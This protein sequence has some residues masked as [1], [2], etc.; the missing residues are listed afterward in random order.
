[1][2]NFLIALLLVVYTFSIGIKAQDK[3]F[4]ED[5]Y[6]Y[7]ENTEVYEVGQEDGRAFHIPE[8]AIS[9]NG[10]WKF[11]YADNPSLIPANFFEA[12][13]NTKS[14]RE[15]E[16]PSNWEMQGFGQPLFR[17]TP[18]PFKAN[19]PFIPHD[20][21]PTGAYKREFTIPSSW[22][23][24]QIFLRFE[25]VA[26]A[27]FVWI[28][29]Q[30]VGYNEGAQEPSEY[31]VT[32]Y[33]KPGKNSLAV[34]VTKYS[35]G[36]YLEGQD[37]WRLAGIFDDVWIYATKQARIFDWYVVTDFDD[38]YTD[39]N[40]SI[41]VDVRTYDAGL[42]GF[43][44]S[45]EVSRGGVAVAKMTERSGIMEPKA[46]RNI[47]LKALVKSPLKWTAET[48]ELYDMT[49]TLTDGSDKLI[50]R[51][52]KKIGFKKT[53]IV[54]GVFL[55]NGKKIKVNAI[56]SHMQH[57]DLGHTM[58]E[59]TI[60]KDMELLKKFNFNG[61]R[62]SHY[63]PVNRYLELADEYGLYIIDEC[64]DEAHAT[65]YLSSKPEWEAMYRERSRK[66]VLRDRNYPSILFWSAGNE[67][68]EGPNIAAV[69]DEGRKYDPTRFWM[70]GGNDEKNPAEDIIGP[71]YPLPLE[72][73]VLYGLDKEDMRPSFMDE[74]LSIAGNGG[75][76]MT[77]YWSVIY[78]HDKIL[79][80]AIWDFVSPG[81]TEYERVIK[82]ESPYNTQVSIMGRAKRNKG[83]WGYCLD[84]HTTDQW[85]EVYRADNVEVD[86]N[87]ITLSM[88]VFP[89]ERNS[90][91]GYFLTKG[92]NQ[93]G[94]RQIGEE[95]LLFYIDTGKRIEIFAELPDDWKNNWHN[96][97]AVYDGSKMKLFIDGSLVAEGNA[98]GNIRNLPWPICIGR[99][100]ESC[101]QETRVYFCDAIVDNVRIFTEAY[102]PN[103]EL[104][105]D[106]SVLW[107]DFESETQGEKYFS[108]GIGA[109]TY[110]AIWPDRV[111]QPEMWEFKKSTQ[112]LE[113]DLLN[114]EEGLVEF[115][116]RNSFTDAS[117]Y[118]TTWT[119]TEDE[120][121]LQSG[122][123]DLSG[124]APWSRTVI[125]VPFKKPASLV[126]GKEY[127][128]NF[129]TVLKEDKLWAQKGHEVSWGQFELK[130][131]NIPAPTTP[132]SG[133]VSMEENN[134]MI[135]VS[136]NGFDYKFDAMSGALVSIRID[137]KE[138]LTSPIKFNVWRAPMANELDGW[139]GGTVRNAQ[140]RPGYANWI[141]SMFYTYGV[142]KLDYLPA[143]IKVQK[144]GDAVI[145]DVREV[146]L[147]NR[148]TAQMSQRDLYIY[149]FTAPGFENVYRY[150][151][152]GDGTVNIY[153][154]VNPQGNMPLWLPRIGL[155]MTLNGSLSN[156][157]W[158][159]RGPQ[160][161]Y[162]DRKRG[163]RVGIFDTTV[164]DMYEPYLIPQDFGLRTD[165]RWVRM[166][167][168]EGNG[169][170]F[171][172]NEL[173][174][175]NVYEY[176][177]DNL[178]KASYQYQI[179]KTDNLT[180][181]LDYATSGVGCSAKGIFNAYKA[182]PT[183]YNRTVTIRPY[184]K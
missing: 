88:D 20:L 42:E 162:P 180:F 13:F 176:S 7:L 52:S 83:P 36:Y 117:Q 149:G 89:R 35:D 5:L 65:E 128:L 80:G 37:Y 151:V 156:V 43:M 93:F 121:V 101:G 146:V 119:L 77:D 63:P 94:I 18:T 150:T 4:M 124:L 25:K 16:V 90:S 116:N 66:M 70:Y 51:I 139:N 122:I 1:M 32:K 100:E 19:P 160:A 96:L 118:V 76:G 61:V 154:S 79:G 147:F 158:Y 71:R 175:F 81:L 137:G 78:R 132:H 138:I 123:V 115:W 168:N 41:D 177:T 62:T 163:Y 10:K 184:R 120:K 106:K 170:E 3:P 159:G 104:T 59:E 183:A 9:L 142:D 22:K 58:D 131:W 129:T 29:G 69:V 143:E 67:S 169:V 97:F 105:A 155:T 64:G 8:P 74:Y 26:S 165:N 47:S 48:P 72:H 45:A 166:T 112:P 98:T 75:G 40:L 133:T 17:N 86:G 107:L 11:L 182:Y 136:G 126:P 33:V 54:D 141:V 2:R 134:S 82:D 140:I 125:Q 173:F 73:E 111:P 46:R 23:G 60:R 164:S 15:I 148:D 153:H 179:H 95:R 127:R 181:N 14:F 108:H 24:Q 103:D 135:V 99:D 167:D 34:L 91:G 57:P 12:N 152:Y 30:Q 56:N 102:A 44:V 172:C 21:N 53:E 85:V 38:T 49:L 50:E 157:E 161:N 87:A 130:D 114:I 174:N 109:R 55:L 145:V 171:S 68:G 178:T 84:L 144:A 110:G 31:N 113:F 39:S 28:N 27:S 6:Y 92:S